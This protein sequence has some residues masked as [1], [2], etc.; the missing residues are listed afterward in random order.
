MKHDRDNQGIDLAGR[1]K[2]LEQF[3]GSLVTRPQTEVAEHEPVPIH[4]APPSQVPR[5]RR[6]RIFLR[7][8]A[9]RHGAFA[10]LT[11]TA[12]QPRTALD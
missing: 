6:S 4:D 5:P 7:S 12:P 9:G 2:S 11:V 10:D 3:T 1:I 8:G